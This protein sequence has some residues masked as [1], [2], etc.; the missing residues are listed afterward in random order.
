MDSEQSHLDQSTP[1]KRPHLY[2]LIN[3]KEL[4]L[5]YFILSAIFI[6]GLVI[7]LGVIL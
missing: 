1:K 5:D 7:I 3:I 4:H 6:L 2:D